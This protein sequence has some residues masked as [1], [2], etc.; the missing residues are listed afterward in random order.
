MIRQHHRQRLSTLHNYLEAA[1]EDL[2]DQGLLVKTEMLEGEPAFAILSRAENDP[3]V[4]MIVMTTRGRSDL[5]RLITS[6]VAD[7]V[8]Q[9]SP[10]PLL[11][12]H[13]DEGLRS[14]QRFYEH[15]YHTI[16]VPLDGSR[17]AEQA[18][19]QAQLLAHATRASLLLLSVT[20]DHTGG[21]IGE[22][23]LDPEW[24]DGPDDA[25][26]DWRG[27]Y[28][29]QTAEPL[30]SAGLPVRIQVGHGD[31]AGEIIWH[32]GQ[33]NA[34][35]I[36]MS[37]RGGSELHHPWPGGVARRVAQQAMLPVLLVRA[38]AVGRQEQIE[39]KDIAGTRE[40]FVAYRADRATE[41]IRRA[42]GQAVELSVRERGQ[43]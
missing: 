6:S 27:S 16:L 43:D 42:W 23:T 1:A 14:I 11:L 13:S 29:S 15:T 30:A 41:S 9:A 35:L 2:R 10:V 39:D 8:L 21:S 20:P 34:D 12:V 18:L 24:I 3:G 38:R 40:E 32:A 25:G 26:E 19:E 4:D 37:T 28:L 22:E 7:K 36:V 17:L 33:A 31:P 5:E